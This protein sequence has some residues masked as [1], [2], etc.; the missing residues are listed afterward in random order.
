MLRLRLNPRAKPDACTIDAYDSAGNPVKITITNEDPAGRHA[1]GI[2][3]TAPPQ[4]PIYR[5]KHAPRQPG[6]TDAQILAELSP[7]Q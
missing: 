1:I 7:V 6:Q 2:G 5:L 3:I 4:I